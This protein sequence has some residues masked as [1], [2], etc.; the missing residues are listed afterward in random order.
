MMCVNRNGYNSRNN[1]G[2]KRLERAGAAA[3]ESG[4]TAR[5]WNT[6]GRSGAARWSICDITHI[7]WFNRLSIIRAVQE[8]GYVVKMVSRVFKNDQERATA[9]Q[10]VSGQLMRLVNPQMGRELLIPASDLPDYLTFQYIVSAEV[11]K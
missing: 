6:A 8:A 1:H 11:G 5:E 10:S 7:R 9:N 3:H 2:K 4:S